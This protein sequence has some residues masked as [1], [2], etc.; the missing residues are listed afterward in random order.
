MGIVIWPDWPWPL[1]SLDPPAP[2]PAPAAPSERP[3]E[4]PASHP[5][6]SEAQNLR[7]DAVAL[8]SQPISL[9]ATSD[10]RSICLDS[11]VL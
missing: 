11:A 9:A 1:P 8:F 10:A 6:P 4:T 2:P 5:G 3:D 7:A